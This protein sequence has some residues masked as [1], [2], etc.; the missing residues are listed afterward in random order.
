MRW[1]PAPVP[2]SVL[3]STRSAGAEPA[4][5]RCVAAVVSAGAGASLHDGL[6]P[7]L[8]PLAGHAGGATLGDGPGDGLGVDAS[9]AHEPALDAHQDA[10]MHVERR[11]GLRASGS[12]DLLVALDLGTELAEAEL[13]LRGVGL[14]PGMAF[15]LPEVRLEAIEPA[16][17]G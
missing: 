6:E 3:S 11:R 13:V 1:M 10:R 14:A 2:E 16:A 7:A 8:V 4:S 17:D 12:Q 5:S 9:H 15:H